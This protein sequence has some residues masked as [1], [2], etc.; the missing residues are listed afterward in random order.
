[1]S[2]ITGASQLCETL[3]QLHTGMSEG[4]I[5]KN[6][7]KHLFT[8]HEFAESASSHRA[9]KNMKY[10]WLQISQCIFHRFSRLELSYIYSCREINFYCGVMFPLMHCVVKLSLNLA[11]RF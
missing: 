8:L 5:H 11:P 1:M 4:S 10:C 3:T 9:I 6:K 2:V 7:N